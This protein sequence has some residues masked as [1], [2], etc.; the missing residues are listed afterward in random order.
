M[1][2]RDQS[3]ESVNKLPERS[4]KAAH[5]CVSACVWEGGREN[6]G[7]SGKLVVLPVLLHTIAAAP[8]NA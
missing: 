2:A 4:V 1:I 6:R 7:G 8:R 3:H 5:A